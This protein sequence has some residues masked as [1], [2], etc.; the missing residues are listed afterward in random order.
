MGPNEFLFLILP[1]AVLVVILVVVVY[2]LAVKNDAV[3]HNELETLNELM[4]M[5]ALDKDNFSETLQGWSLN[6]WRQE[7]LRE[8]TLPLSDCRFGEPRRLEDSLE[9]GVWV[10]SYLCVFVV[11]ASRLQGGRIVKA[12]LALKKGQEKCK[13][14]LGR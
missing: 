10:A 13:I 12:G 11:T 1:L 7:F 6:C 5:G 14:P 2:R 8:P 9:A 4:Q 3:R